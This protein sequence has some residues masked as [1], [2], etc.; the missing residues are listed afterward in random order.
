MSDDKCP[1]AIVAAE[2]PLD[3]GASLTAGNEDGW[4]L[5]FS[6]NIPAEPPVRAE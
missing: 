1:V 2:A 3:R 4:R 5:I 6:A